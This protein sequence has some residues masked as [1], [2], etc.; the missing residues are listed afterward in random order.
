MG[1]IPGTGD[2]EDPEHTK[3]TPSLP[4]WQEGEHKHLV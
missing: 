2:K 1:E 3:I 4:Q